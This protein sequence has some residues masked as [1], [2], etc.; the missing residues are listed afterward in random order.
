MRRST[1][2]PRGSSDQPGAAWKHAAPT[3]TLDGS[4]GTRL[5]PPRSWEQGA[6]SIQ[7]GPGIARDPW[8]GWVRESVRQGEQQASLR[9]PERDLSCAAVPAGEG[10]ADFTCL[11]GSGCQD[12]DFRGLAGL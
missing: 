12:G 1:S 8:W 4:S 5:A 9:R 10:R 11:P 2:W 6:R 3:L 7:A